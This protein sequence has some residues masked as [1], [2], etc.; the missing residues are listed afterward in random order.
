MNV[1]LVVR[2][3]LSLR[4]NKS[5]VADT[6][7]SLYTLTYVPTTHSSQIEQIRHK[8]QQPYEQRNRNNPLIITIDKVKREHRRRRPRP[9]FPLPFSL[10][11]YRFIV[12]NVP[13]VTVE[14]LRWV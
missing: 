8:H 5:H 13:I 14:P 7:K 12:I 10:I 2:E 6:L 3:V 4:M 11:I 9:R 1:K